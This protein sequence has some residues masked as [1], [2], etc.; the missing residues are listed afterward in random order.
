M[1]Q[2]IQPVLSM[3]EITAAGVVKGDFKIVGGV[4]R[5]VLSGRIVEILK[6]ASNKDYD[7]S[8]RA[9]NEAA[10]LS[11]D[12]AIKEGTSLSL[13]NKFAV[14]T[15]VIVGI[16]ALGY[17]SYKLYTYLKNTSKKD[18]IDDSVQNDNEIIVYHS[19]LTEYFNNMQNQSMSLSSIR[20]AFDFF[21]KYGNSDV[22]IDI[23]QDEMLIIRNII[24][25]YTIKLCES[26]NI[27][28][29]NK[30]LYIDSQSLNE[31]DLLKEIVY[32]TK[33][34]EEIFAM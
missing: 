28:L 14:G 27:S 16:G 33:V 17:G 12:I 8:R 30:E 25:K 7:S 19:E 22:S 21:D 34:Q 9:I 29:E 24:I 23:T 31:K 10:K 18:Q 6:D 26:N 1:Q 13:K 15:L 20:E 3:S 2:I 5:D 11:K 32:A 4:V